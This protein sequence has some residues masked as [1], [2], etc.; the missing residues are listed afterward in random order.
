MNPVS[1]RT[2]L[3]TL[4]KARLADLGR[5]LQLDLAPGAPKDALVQAVAAAPAARLDDLL[6]LLLRDELKAAERPER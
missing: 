1:P 2:V 6:P 3:G 5:S 4:T